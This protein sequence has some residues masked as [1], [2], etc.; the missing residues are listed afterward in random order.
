MSCTRSESVG[1]GL[2]AIGLVNVKK[3]AGLLLRLT[4]EIPGRRGCPQLTRA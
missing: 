1:V 3:K 4:F 2:L